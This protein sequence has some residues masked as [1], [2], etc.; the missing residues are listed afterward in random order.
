MAVL[1]WRWK[2]KNTASFMWTHWKCI[3]RKK[4]QI[5][6]TWL[7]YSWKVIQVHTLYPR[8][9][10]WWNSGLFIFWRLRNS[11]RLNENDSIRHS[12]FLKD[13][14]NLF[15][16]LKEKK[17]FWIRNPIASV[18]AN[19]LIMVTELCLFLHCIYEFWCCISGDSHRG[20]CEIHRWITQGPVWA[21]TI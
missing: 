3:N 21:A 12:K 16:F 10:G 19:V 2:K 6:C 1:I 14:I 8:L 11:N 17:C 13:N 5:V 9:T 15:Q 20:S 18:E 7:R 4:L